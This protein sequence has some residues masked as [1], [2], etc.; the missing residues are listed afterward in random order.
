MSKSL[1]CGT[2]AEILAPGGLV[3]L[4]SSWERTVCRANISLGVGAGV[5]TGLVV[6][7]GV[8][9]LEPSLGAGIV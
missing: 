8:A 9:E 7:C 3:L 4:L 2:G 5:T 1:T 6:C